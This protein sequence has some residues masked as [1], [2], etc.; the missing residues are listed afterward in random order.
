[1]PCY[2]P[3]NEISFWSWAGGEYGCLNPFATGRGFELKA[4]L[5]R[6]ALAAIDAV[7]SVDSRARILHADPLIHIEADPERPEDVP[8]ALG[9]R[10]A[11][12]QGWDLLAGELWPQL[13]GDR[14]YLDLLGVNYYPNNQ[15]ILNGP[16][17]ERGSPLHRPLR[18][19]LREVWERY[20][21]PLVL[22]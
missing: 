17:I 14:R 1:V 2:V 6:A 22:T 13:G 5:V 18:D 10:Q 8:L 21:R 7:W 9:P 16:T 12:F 4:Q 11:Q 15:W 19:L 20:R 3:I